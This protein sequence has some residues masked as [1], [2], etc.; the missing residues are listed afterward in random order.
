MCVIDINS[1]QTALECA[2]LLPSQ[3]T[4]FKA[5]S[6][7]PEQTDFHQAV[8]VDN[9]RVPQ[10]ERPDVSCPHLC[11]ALVCFSEHIMLFNHHL[12]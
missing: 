9:L 11:G 10:T 6:F 7:H 4:Y 8:D 3:C 5:V 1:S 2:H 12:A